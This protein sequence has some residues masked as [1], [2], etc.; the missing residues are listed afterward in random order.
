MVDLQAHGAS[1]GQDH[2]FYQVAPEPQVLQEAEGLPGVVS[3]LAVGPLQSVQLLQYRQRQHDVVVLEGL[4]GVGGLEEDIGVQHIG[5]L[6][7]L[8]LP[9]CFFMLGSGARKNS[10][11][12]PHK[13]ANR[14]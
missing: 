6:H 3:R 2:A 13:G 4:Q 11:G 7:T 5:L 12:S 10:A 1:T 9:F 14:R 8:R